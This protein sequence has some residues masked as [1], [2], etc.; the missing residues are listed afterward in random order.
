M[1]DPN[2]NAYVPFRMN[3]IATNEKS[4]DEFIPLNPRITPC[5]VAPNVSMQKILKYVVFL[6]GSEF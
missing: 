1:G 4:I 3:Y 6:F 5:N 2:S